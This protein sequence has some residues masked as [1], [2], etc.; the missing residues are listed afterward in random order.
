MIAT[1][2][3]RGRPLIDWPVSTQGQA[4]LEKVG[5]IITP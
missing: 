1:W 2:E 3:A 5:V 4:A